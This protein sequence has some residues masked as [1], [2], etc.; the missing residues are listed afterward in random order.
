MKLVELAVSGAGHF[1]SIGLKSG[2]LRPLRVVAPGADAGQYLAFAISVSLALGAAAFAAALLFLVSP[3]NAY[4]SAIAALACFAASFFFVMGLPGMEMRMR[5]AAIEAEMPL[6]LRTMGMLLDMRVPFVNAVEIVSEGEGGLSEEMGRVAL[7]IR[8]GVTV[9]RAFSRF[10][11][12]YDSFPIKRAVAQL[13]SAYEVGGSGQEIKRIGDELMAI[14]QHKL[15]Q[16]ASKSAI[17]GLLF[18]VSAAVLPTFFLIY[19]VL[20]RFAFDARVSEGGIATGMLFLFPM[21]SVLVLLMSRSTMP[22]SP[23]RKSGG[24]ELAMALPAGVFL[25]SVL[26][27]PQGLAAFGIAGGTAIAALFTYRS[28]RRDRRTEELE[29]FLPDGL[30]SVSGL[31]KST[32][33]ERVFGIIEGGGY[34]ALS[35]EAGKSRKQIQGN[36]GTD[37]V[38]ED[39]ALRNDSRM[40]GRAAMMLRHVFRTN[41][42]DRLNGLAEDML[43]S[44]EIMR[45]R[46]QMAS[47][48][49]Y[50]LLFGAL[51]IPLILKTTLNLLSD[52]GGFFGDG[53]VPGLVAFSFSLMPAYLVIYSVISSS[54]IG[55]MEGRKSGAMGYF[56]MMAAAGLSAFYLIDI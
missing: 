8:G 22:A 3:S 11:Q 5:A 29:R 40:L 23:F 43:K 28:Y 26:F 30:F 52:M 25:G 50:T 13:L 19:S 9:H 44:F 54:Y 53:G 51:L 35:E 10:A 16:H 15:K 36:L 27:V 38:L 21:I 4:I 12:S 48:Q 45:E 17:F 14:E 42:F 41:S 46:A 7:E 32:G 56:L 55:D 34:G 33:M 39:L 18:I 37:A 1:P 24:L 49:K 47:L 20:G 6:A 31:P 2:M